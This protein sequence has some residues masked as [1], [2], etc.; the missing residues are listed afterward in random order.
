MV[1]RL[2]TVVLLDPNRRICAMSVDVGP[3]CAR[4]DSAPLSFIT[5]AWV[6][7]TKCHYL[8]VLQ[9]VITKTK[10]EITIQA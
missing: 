5:M 7:R 2:S 4:S 1:E 3:L 10:T 9:E 6:G 8:S